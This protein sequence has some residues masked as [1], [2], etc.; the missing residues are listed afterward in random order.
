M[1]SP[2][3][4]PHMNIWG[5][6]APLRDTFYLAPGIV[7]WLPPISS[8]RGRGEGGGQCYQPKLA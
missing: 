2:C 3:H 5:F 4:V 1:G 8:K 6:K 7:A